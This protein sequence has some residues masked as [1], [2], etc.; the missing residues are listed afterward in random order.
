M[1]F[2]SGGFKLPKL[3]IPTWEDV[4]SSMK[5]PALGGVFGGI[6]NVIKIGAG[7]GAGLLGGML[8][9]GGKQEQNAAPQTM[10]VTPTITQAPAPVIT[11]V[12]EPI[13]VTAAEQKQDIITNT[14]TT[15]S[16]TTKIYDSENVTIGGVTQAAETV[17]IPTQTAAVTPTQTTPTIIPIVTGAG[18]TTQPSQDQALTAEQTSDPSTLILIAGAALI[19]FMMLK[20]EGGIF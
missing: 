5:V 14:H 12:T 17:T 15:F 16:N 20:K 10:D 2:I 19:G 11:P 8:L 4:T 3:A 1:A 18:Q 9:G 6:G 7:V 13:Q